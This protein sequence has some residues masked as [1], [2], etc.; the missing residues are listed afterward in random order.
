MDLNIGNMALIDEFGT[1]LHSVDMSNASIQ[2]CT[3][4]CH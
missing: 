3:I 2:R 4:H 1:D